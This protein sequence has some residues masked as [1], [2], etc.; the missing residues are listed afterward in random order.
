MDIPRR[1]WL[2]GHSHTRKVG[3]R[4][5]DVGQGPMLGDHG[6]ILRILNS[7]LLTKGL[8]GDQGSLQDVYTQGPVWGCRF[9]FSVLGGL[10]LEPKLKL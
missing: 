10:D 8:S 7:L 5:P 4:G 1:N 2:C 6:V 9:Q 3:S